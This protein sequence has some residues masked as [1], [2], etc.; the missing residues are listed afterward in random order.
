MSNFSF[1][2]KQE[3]FIFHLPLTLSSENRE[4]QKNQMALELIWMGKGEV[5]D[6]NGLT[7]IIQKKN[8]DPYPRFIARTKFVL[9][10]TK[11]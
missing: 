6:P 9:F 2:L 8:L 4:E 11:T 3:R 1:V 7:A 10:T 5:R